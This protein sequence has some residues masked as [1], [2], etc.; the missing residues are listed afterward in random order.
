MEESKVSLCEIPKSAEGLRDALFD[1]INA[2]RTGKG[3][4]QRARV[5]SQLA[6]RII[7][8]ARLSIQVNGNLEFKRKTLLGSENENV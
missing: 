2:L 6:H 3:D 5:I 8:A 7:E 1:E 4:V